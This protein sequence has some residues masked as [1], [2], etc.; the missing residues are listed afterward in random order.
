ML[1][2]Q[3]LWVNLLTHGVPGV[4]LG[5]EPAEPNIMRR[6][7]RPPEESVLGAGLGR[8]VLGT[9]VLLAVTVLGA[10]LAA[11]ALDLPWQSVIFVVLGLAQLGIAL[12]VRATRVPG[13]ERNPGLLVAVAIS[14]AMQVAGVLV[15]PL[16]TLLGTQALTPIVLLGCATLAALP[17][18]T[19]VAIRR[20]SA[21]MPR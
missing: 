7:P 11:N 16:R 4:A 21:T 13:G 20:V 14:A 19:L 15:P 6:A 5:A 3:I 17:A 9:G 12:A 18:L 8:S 1:P 10:G 2:A